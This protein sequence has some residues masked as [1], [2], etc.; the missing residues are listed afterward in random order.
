MV[1]SRTV[2]I[3]WGSLGKAAG[4]WAKSPTTHV[5]SRSSGFSYRYLRRQ[6]VQGD[7][8]HGQ[9]GMGSL[10]LS[11]VVCESNRRTKSISRT[12]PQ[13][14]SRLHCHTSTDYPLLTLFT[15]FLHPFDLFLYSLFLMSLWHKGS[16]F[17]KGI[18][19]NTHLFQKD[20]FKINRTFMI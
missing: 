7:C 18:E 9:S 13:A 12:I 3:N 19:V 10:L 5:A 14:R 16:L 17:F 15:P 11:P 1:P 2:S 8:G 4:V 20:V 6:E